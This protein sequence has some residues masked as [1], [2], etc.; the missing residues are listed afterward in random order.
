[1]TVL[2]AVPNVSEGCDPEPLANLEKALG[3]GVSLLDRHTDADH[4]RTVFTLAGRPGP[5]MEALVAAAEEAL[6]TI[7]MSRY[8]G[9]H[10]AIG[11]LDVCP[12][13]WLDRAD[14]DAAR[15]EAV[16][17]AAQIGGLGIPVFLYGELAATRPRVIE[18]RQVGGWSTRATGLRLE[19]AW[20][21]ASAR[22]RGLERRVLVSMRPPWVPRCLRRR[23]FLVCAMA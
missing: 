4:D 21:F 8:G 17:A 13:V 14:R 5:L 10:P 18:L 6:E 23:F 3:R 9:A 20:A 19:R 2:L 12:L 7:D 11:A 22:L 16:A 15:T 1:M